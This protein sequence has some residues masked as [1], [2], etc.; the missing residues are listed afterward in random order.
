MDD[1]YFISQEVKANESQAKILKI[2]RNIG[3][4]PASPKA[5]TRSEQSLRTSHR[6]FSVR[7]VPQTKRSLS[8]DRSGHLR[9]RERDSSLD[10]STVRGA[11]R[12]GQERNFLF[13]SQ[14]E[15]SEHKSRI[16]SIKI[17][18]RGN[19]VASADNEG[20][21]KIWS[22]S[23]SCKTSAS[24]SSKSPITCVDWVPNHERYVIYGTSSSIIGLYD[25]KEFKLM[26][27][28]NMEND[29]NK[30]RIEDIICS[31]AESSAIVVFA[32]KLFLIDLKMRKIEKI[33]NMPC[34]VTCAKMNHNGQL[35]IVGSADGFV[36]LA[37]IRKNEVIK[38]VGDS[39]R[40][41]PAYGIDCRLY[42]GVHT[43]GGQ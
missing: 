42:F 21:L 4:V 5:E 30:G 23:S 31:P 37:D 28:M 25:I 35:A 22:I 26:W 34:E 27:E 11:A 40:R 20:H 36:L 17:N 15:Y 14:E 9:V 19:L 1:F 39:Q 32:G 41:C 33:L 43:R 29:G 3:S 18:N 16:T 2:M 10:L 13:L 6:M 8:I 24:H 7:R 12:D 38:K